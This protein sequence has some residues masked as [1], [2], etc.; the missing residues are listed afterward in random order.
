MRFG[1]LGV[2][3]LADVSGEGGRRAKLFE[4]FLGICLGPTTL[5]CV[6]VKKPVKWGE[7]I[8]TVPALDPQS[9]GEDT[10]SVET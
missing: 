7:I 10:H 5:Q 9:K 8:Y 2:A 1:V 4:L 6:W 3:E